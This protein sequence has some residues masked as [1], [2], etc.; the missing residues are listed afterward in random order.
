MEAFGWNLQSRQEIHEEGDAFGRPSLGLL[1]SGQYIIKTKVSRYV[2]LHFVRALALPNL[3]GIRKLESEYSNLPFPAPLSLRWPIILTLFPF[4]GIIITLSKSNP[5]YGG[6]V[7]ILI[8]IVWMFFS[9]RWLLSRM[10]KDGD[11]QETRAA[12]IK[13]A[14]E[15]MV[16]AQSLAVTQ[17]QPV[18]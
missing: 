1:S 18:S 2:K 15:I 10:R 4:L 3:A 16:E 11:A 13:K 17:L 6:P 5:L 7:E 8:G 14:A 9:I 12:S